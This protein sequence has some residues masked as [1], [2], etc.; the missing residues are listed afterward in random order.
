MKI[1][2][3]ICALL[4]CTASASLY[5]ATF[6]Q[7]GDIK[8]G[9]TWP[10]TEASGVASY[11]AEGKSGKVE[12]N[13]DLQGIIG[14]DN[15]PVKATLVPG[16]NFSNEYNM[17]LTPLSEGVNGPFIWTLTDE[18]SDVGNIKVFYASG[19]N[20]TIQCYGKHL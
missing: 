18:K 15:K 20:V 7:A 6:F 5:A 14:H 4:T 13:C 12:F 8:N 16:K 11:Y 2:H 17:P 10:I 19:S 9:Q 1:K 3:L